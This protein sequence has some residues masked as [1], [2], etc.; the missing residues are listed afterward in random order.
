MTPT[1]T[2]IDTL[3]VGIR[4]K[5]SESKLKENRIE[6]E[7]YASTRFTEAE[8]MS[9]KAYSA[10]E[11]NQYIYFVS[12]CGEFKRNSTWFIKE[13]SKTNLVLENIKTKKIADF[14]PKEILSQHFDVLEKK[15]IEIREGE[16]LLI[17]RNDKAEIVKPIEK[18]EKT[19]GPE[20]GSEI[21]S[22]HEPKSMVHSVPEIIKA[23]GKLQ[24]TTKQVIP[25]KEIHKFTNGELVTVKAIKDGNL[26]LEDGRT[27]TDAVKSFDYG[28]VSTSYSSQGKTCDHVIVAM[29]NAGGRALSQEQFYVST[30]RGREGIDIF[31]ED[32]EYI[33]ARIEEFGDRSFN[34]EVG[35]KETSEKLK[36]FKSDSLDQLKIKSL[37]VAE[38]FSLNIEKEK[39]P[40][41]IQEKEKKLVDKV[42]DK[43]NEIYTSWKEKIIK[44]RQKQIEPI[45][46]QIDKQIAASLQRIKK[47]QYP[48]E[49]EPMLIHEKI[50]S[51]GKSLDMD[52]DI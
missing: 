49:R 31:I 9:L 42:I 10:R 30:S 17:Q 7:V 6:R 11:E 50:M 32:K 36:N 35:S 26:L 15:T 47:Q 16:T 18:I 21:D 43:A 38:K 51:K 13:V 8:K 19:H 37:E 14:N 28:Y 44:A 4:E 2:E 48:L 29:T 1:R 20:V 45:K 5:L 3:T 52:R 24:E 46:D 34:F 22:K 40:E 33:K 41:Q 23:D 27:I 25:E 12:N 39:G